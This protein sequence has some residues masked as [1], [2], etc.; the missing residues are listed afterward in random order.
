MVTDQTP[1]M[2][3]NPSSVARALGTVAALLVLANTVA[4]MATYLTGR[5]PHDVRF[6]Q[7]FYLDGE[8]NI[9]TAF[10]TLLLLFAALLLA[11]ITALERK[12]TGSAVLPWAVLSCGFLFMAVDEAWSFHE[13]LTGPVRTL[14]GNA[15]LGVFYYSWVIPAIGL[16]LVLGL[17]F[18]RF[19]LRLPAKTKFTFLMAAILFLGG[20]IGIEL[21]EGRF[22]ELHGDRNLTSGLT[23]PVQETL[24]MAGVIV[25]IWGLLVYLADQYKEVRIRFERESR[26]HDRRPTGP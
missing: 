16:V 18:F 9:P 15:D 3:L 13:K 17:F 5:T 11:V 19:L 1:Q 12:R 23:A 21:I 25:L 10:S 6:A 8:R 20:A 4:L 24:E 2:T 22:D 26:N 14:L 7:L